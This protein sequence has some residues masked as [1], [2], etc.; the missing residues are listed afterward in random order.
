MPANSTATV[1]VPTAPDQAIS[2]VSA[3]VSGG[4]TTSVQS[5]VVD[6][7]KIVVTLSNTG[8]SDETVTLTVEAVVVLY[9]AFGKKEKTI[10]F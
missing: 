10:R 8:A 2:V 7:G 1:E 5:T 6:L 4:S 9:S 3:T